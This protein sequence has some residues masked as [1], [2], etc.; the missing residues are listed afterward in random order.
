MHHKSNQTCR[1]DCIQ[2]HSSLVPYC[3]CKVSGVN[4]GLGYALIV[5]RTIC[6]LLLQTLS[7]TT[8]TSQWMRSLIV[9]GWNYPHNY[10]QKQMRRHSHFA[11][12]M[13]ISKGDISISHLFVDISFLFLFICGIL[14]F[15]LVSYLCGF[16]LCGRKLFEITLD[17]GSQRMREQ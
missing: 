12:N 14:Q 11:I 2:L 16:L 6:L 9:T 13:Q 8:T 1:L 7:C 15:F 5:V 4:N 17:T 3:C 10:I